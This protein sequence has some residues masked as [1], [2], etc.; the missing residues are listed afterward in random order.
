MPHQPQAAFS[1]YTHSLQ[2]E[3]VYLQHVVEVKER[4]FDSLE[5]AINAKLLPALFKTNVIPPDLW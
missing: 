3:W 4:L 1:G 2:F 5:E